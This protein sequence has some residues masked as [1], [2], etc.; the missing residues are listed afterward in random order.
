MMPGRDAFG[1]QHPN[2][3][4]RLAGRFVA[5]HGVT[6][7]RY[8]A[9][10]AVTTPLRVS[11]RYDRSRADSVTE[12]GFTGRVLREPNQTRT[13]PQ[14][15]P[16]SATPST[17]DGDVPDPAER[18]AAGW[19]TEPRGRPDRPDLPDSGAPIGERSSRQAPGVAVL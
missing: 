1:R 3:P 5:D 19:S 13:D 17:F 7:L 6:V 11:Q 18:P 10:R 2:S 16:L 12:V 8:R 15:S 9:A 4:S 14:N